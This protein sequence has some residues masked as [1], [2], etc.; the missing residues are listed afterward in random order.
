[1]SQSLPWKDP[2]EIYDWWAEHET[3]R[4]RA[5]RLRHGRLVAAR[6]K[7]THDKREWKIL[8]DIFGGC[9]SCG[10]PYSSLYG[11]SATK[12]HIRPIF[13]GGCDCI[14]NLQP[15]CRQCNSAGGLP[16]MR[17]AALPGWQTIYLH[18]IGSY[19]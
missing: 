11:G 15:L 9:V 10:T 18:R 7:G 4:E 2:T 17:D 5:G 6:Q 14:A 19:F 8:H 16:D 12:D 13:I 3:A 1:M